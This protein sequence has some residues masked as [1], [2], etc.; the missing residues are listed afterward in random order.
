M[1]GEFLDII[2]RQVPRYGYLPMLRAATG[3][4]LYRGEFKP[5]PKTALQAAMHQAQ[6]QQQEGAQ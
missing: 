2:V 4:E 3:E 6:R 5:D 1:K